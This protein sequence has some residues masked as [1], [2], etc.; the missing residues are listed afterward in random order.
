MTVAVFGAGSIGCY[1]G[2]R[3]ADAGADVVLVGRE[4]LAQEVAAHGLRITD[5]QGADL[6]VERVRYETA[7]HAAAGADLVLVTV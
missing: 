1:V 5:W 2:G 7:A 4:W 3:L 6:A